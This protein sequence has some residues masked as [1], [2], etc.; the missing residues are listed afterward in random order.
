LQNSFTWMEE[1]ATIMFVG[2]IYLGVSS[3]V[4][5]RKHLRIDFF[6]DLVPFKVKKI[7]LVFSNVIFA[8]FNIYIS[9]IWQILLA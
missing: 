8:V 1:F 5:K 4:T 6:L 7:M 3:A 9:F 2:M